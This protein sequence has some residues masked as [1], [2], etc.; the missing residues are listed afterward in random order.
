MAIQGLRTTANFIAN[1]R[2]EN[3]REGIM[4]LYPNGMAPLTAL[5][6]LMGSQSVDDPHY[7]W[8][9]K[10]M[11]TRRV[12]ITADLN[13]TDIT[14]DVAVA[15]GA[16]AFK[17]G[18]IFYVESTGEL[19]YVAPNPSSDTVLT[20]I[21]GMSNSTKTALTVSGANPFMTCIGS[22]YE[23]ASNAPVGIAFD[24]NEQVN[25]TQIFRNTHEITGTAAETNVR[26]G[27]EWKEQKRETLELHSIDMERA[28]FFGKKSVSIRNGKP[29]RTTG[30][31]LSTIPSANIHTYSTPITLDAFESDLVNIFAYGSNEKMAFGG[32]RGLI[33]LQQML[34]RSKG[35]Q[36]EM[37]GDKEYGMAVTRFTY[38]AGGTL[39]IKTHPLFNQMRSVVGSYSAMD[40][41]LVILDMAQLKYKYLKNR[42]TE[43]E[44]D[45]QTPGVDGKKNGFRTE[46]G[47]QVGQAQTHFAIFGL[48]AAAA[49]T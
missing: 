44:T 41:A 9:E 14:T 34:R 16:L 13:N 48:T 21:R 4:L 32:S 30:G 11:Q 12:Q 17:E 29:W 5:T 38:A 20:V 39:V 26:T 22:A 45:L 46:C 28:F 37:Q 27:D 40:A 35:A 7:H 23:E 25:Y 8:F 10:A 1:A 47:L 31:I 49:E 2:P 18:D 15:A 42:D 43:Y 3:W 33:T 36:F 6:S 24:P 19:V